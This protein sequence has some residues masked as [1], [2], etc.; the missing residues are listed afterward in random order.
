[1]N[2]HCKISNQ[3]VCFERLFLSHNM[4]SLFYFKAE[5]WFYF[6]CTKL[7]RINITM[8]KSYLPVIQAK[9]IIRKRT[10]NN[11]TIVYMRVFTDNTRISPCFKVSLYSSQNGWHLSEFWQTD[12]QVEVVYWINWCRQ[13][14]NLFFLWL[15]L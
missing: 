13:K 6:S 2:I 3:I 1:M 9:I 11:A 10:E 7:S 5:F 12:I 14:A 15:H 4:L 8:F